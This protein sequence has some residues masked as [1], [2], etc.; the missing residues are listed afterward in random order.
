[1]PLPLEPA[2]SELVAR[3]EEEWRALQ[4]QQSQLKEVA[5]REAQER[6]REAQ[7]ELCCLREDFVYNL[8]LLEERDHELDRYDTAF[9]Q[10]RQLDGARQAELSELKIQV[11]KLRQALSRETQKV[12]DLKQQ[13]QRTWQEHR[14]QLERLHK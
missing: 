1:M 2:L 4:A 10:A 12:E 13:Q 5:L 11:A 8:K 6:L 14:L 3:K 9:A 7:G